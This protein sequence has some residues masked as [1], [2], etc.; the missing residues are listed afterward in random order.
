M[1]PADPALRRVLNAEYAA[2]LRESQL[3]LASIG[4]V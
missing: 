3:L 1:D 4:C 2:A